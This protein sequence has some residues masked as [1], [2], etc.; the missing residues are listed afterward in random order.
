MV[1]IKNIAWWS[2]VAVLTAAFLTTW[3]FL[4]LPAHLSRIVMGRINGG[5]RPSLA[6]RLSS[7]VVVA[8]RGV[9]IVSIGAVLWGAAWIFGILPSAPDP[10][11]IALD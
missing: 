11:L 6:A 4:A 10:A 7:A 3:A 5:L 2:W 1:L 8:V 9:L